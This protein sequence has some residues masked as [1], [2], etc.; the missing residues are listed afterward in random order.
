MTVV[1]LRCGRVQAR[2]HEREQ[3]ALAEATKSF[4]ASTDILR[5]E[6][7]HK[8]RPSV[9]MPSSLCACVQDTEH[10]D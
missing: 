1:E 4:D 8:V 7:S 3:H 2:G 10:Q 5:Q 9:H 6:L